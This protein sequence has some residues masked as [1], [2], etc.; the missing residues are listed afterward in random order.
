MTQAKPDTTLSKNS[1]EVLPQDYDKGNI[2]PETH[3]IPQHKDI[4]LSTSA[5]PSPTLVPGTGNDDVNITDP[6]RQQSVQH[7]IIA[8][9]Q[10]K[11]RNGTYE[12][13]IA[14]S[15]LVDFGG[16]RSFD[17]THQLFMRHKGTFV[18][19]FNGKTDIR[20]GLGEE[21]TECKLVIDFL[22]LILFF[23]LT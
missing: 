21:T 8:T 18:L 10:E 12:I 3:T 22:N 23:L 6:L 4:T 1:E 17:M 11:I 14:P 20:G 2:I 19:M 9:I 13:E 7:S 16:Q 15:D 5:A